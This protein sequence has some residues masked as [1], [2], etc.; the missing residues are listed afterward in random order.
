[1]EKSFMTMQFLDPLVSKHVINEKFE[2][3]TLC[4]TSSEHHTIRDSGGF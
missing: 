4:A 1:M 3:Y 2:E